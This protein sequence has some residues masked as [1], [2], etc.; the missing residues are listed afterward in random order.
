M[1]VLISEEIITNNIQRLLMHF[2]EKIYNSMEIRIA[3]FHGELRNR[4]K[5]CIVDIGCIFKSQS[6]EMHTH[7]HTQKKP[8]YLCVFQFLSNFCVTCTFT[9]PPCFSRQEYIF[10]AVFAWAYHF[11]RLC[12]P[13][14]VTLFFRKTN[15]KQRHKQ[16]YVYLVKTPSRVQLWCVYNFWLHPQ[17]K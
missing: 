4:K 7:T 12:F 3:K 9:L 17:R 1:Q 13:Y 15:H 10:L 5:S 6:S 11:I 2:H 8:P 16:W 14:K